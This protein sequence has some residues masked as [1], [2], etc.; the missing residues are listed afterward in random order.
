[1]KLIMDYFANDFG[2]LHIG[3]NFT[4]GFAGTLV[5]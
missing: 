1:M 4:L 2:V 3:D 5:G